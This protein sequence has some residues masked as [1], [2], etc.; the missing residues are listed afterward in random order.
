MFAI[1]EDFRKIGP[2]GELMGAT[3][4]GIGNLNLAMMEFGAAGSSAADKVAAG[5][6]VVGSVISMVGQIQKASSDARIKA[7][8][9]EIAAEQKRDGKSAG[10]VEK[11]K[12][13]EKKKDAAARKSFEQ[14]KKMKMA[15][16]PITF[17]QSIFLAWKIL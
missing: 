6:A 3:M 1:A 10:S 17:S 8:D 16:K 12:A 14:Q 2:E 5:L 7:I 15:Q 11:I 9:G 4:E 13:L